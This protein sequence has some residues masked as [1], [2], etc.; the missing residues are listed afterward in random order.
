MHIDPT[1]HDPRNEIEDLV[2]RAIKPA[3]ESMAGQDKTSEKIGIASKIALVVIVGI[4]A[5]LF[6]SAAS[7]SGWTETEITPD[8]RGGYSYERYEV[9]HGTTYG[10]VRPTYG[11]YE[12][13]ESGVNGFSDSNVTIDRWSGRIEVDTFR[14]DW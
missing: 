14:M 7:A 2:Q 5:F 1:G 9:G 8:G 6:Y 10:T 3:M 11:G 4:I 12:I 13:E